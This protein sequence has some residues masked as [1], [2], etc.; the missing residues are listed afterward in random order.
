MAD[1][2]FPLSMSIIKPFVV[3]QDKGS[4]NRIFNY[5]LSRV[6]NAFIV[7]FHILRKPML[8]EPPT[9]MLV[10]LTLVHYTIFCKKKKKSTTIHN[11]TGMV[12]IECSDTGQ[13]NPGLWRRNVSNTELIN[14]D[15]TARSSNATQQVRNKFSES[16]CHR[17]GN[18]IFSTCHKKIFVQT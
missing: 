8:L 5:R 4:K 14:V 6:R 12:D 10:V 15:K 13:I 9:T 3:C 16:F 11:P 1:D 2:A 18:C 17:K 7:V